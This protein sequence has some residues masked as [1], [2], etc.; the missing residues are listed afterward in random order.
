MSENALSGAPSRKE[1]YPQPKVSAQQLSP[2]GQ[3]ARKGK[4][5]IYCRV[6]SCCRVLNTLKRYH[7]RYRICPEHLKMS[8]VTLEGTD[9]RFCQL[10]G[11]FQPLCDFDGAKRSCRAK[12][13][14][15]NERRQKCKDEEAVLDVYREPCRNRNQD[16]KSEPGNILVNNITR[17]GNALPDQ[18]LTGIRDPSKGSMYDT[19]LRLYHNCLQIEG[20]QANGDNI[21]IGR[22][23]SPGTFLP[24]TE[25]RQCMES[26]LKYPLT[27]SMNTRTTNFK[28]EHAGFERYLGSSRDVQPLPPHYQPGSSGHGNFGQYNPLNEMFGKTYPE[29]RLLFQGMKQDTAINLLMG[30]LEYLTK[31]HGAQT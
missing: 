4:H 27:K 2:E 3:H 23:P 9:C 17:Q 29:T 7:R 6:P 16:V 21:G 5:N 31:G 8:H 30:L 13:A 10:C 25:G 24:S 18:L 20:M 19:M 22:Y 11:K 28:S 12:L 1:A 15:H 26:N 14:R